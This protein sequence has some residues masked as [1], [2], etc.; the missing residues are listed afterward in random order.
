MTEKNKNVK[1]AIHCS[2]GFKYFFNV[3]VNEQKTK[4]SKNK[5]IGDWD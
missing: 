1:A 5:T 3:K 2:P 4:Q